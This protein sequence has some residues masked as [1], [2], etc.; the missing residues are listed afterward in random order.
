MKIIILLTTLLA[1]AAA[2]DNL[3]GRHLTLNHGPYVM[4]G[5]GCELYDGDGKLDEIFVDDGAKPVMSEKFC[6]CQ[7]EVDPPEDGRDVVFTYDHLTCNCYDKKGNTLF[8]TEVF[9]ETVLACG[10]ATLICFAPDEE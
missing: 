3:R 10:K 2:S 9:Q 7:A 6:K 5:T 4:E 8:E 1:M